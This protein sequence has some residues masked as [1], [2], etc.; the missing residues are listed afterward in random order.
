L[1]GARCGR[2][3]GVERA[4][5]VLHAQVEVDEGTAD[6]PAMVDAELGF[7]E[8]V[9]AGARRCLRCSCW[10]AGGQPTLSEV[11]LTSSRWIT[12]SARSWWFWLSPS[13]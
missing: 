5:A 6:A 2:C 4:D 9:A 8:A 3:L 10:C 1:P 13:A 7:A 11:L 12:R